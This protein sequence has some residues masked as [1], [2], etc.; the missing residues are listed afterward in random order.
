MDPDAVFKAMLPS[1][2]DTNNDVAG[3]QAIYDQELLAMRGGTDAKGNKITGAL[4]EGVGKYVDQ[5]RSDKSFTDQLPDIRHRIAP[6]AAAVAQALASFGSA[7]SGNQT[8]DQAMR[9]QIQQA[10]Q[11]E[12]AD[13]AQQRKAI[14]EEA[15]NRRMTYLNFQAQQLQTTFQE[16]MRRRQFSAASVTAAKAAEL[17]ALVFNA[18]AEQQAAMKKFDGEVE[19]TKS[20]L[21]AGVFVGPDGKTITTSTSRSA[22]G[23]LFTEKDYNDAV[24][25]NLKAWV[26]A[27]SQKKPDANLLNV[28][29]KR[30][31]ELL[32]TF[33]EN[34]TTE[35][36][37][38]R[39]QAGI[40]NLVAQFGID[41]KAASKVAYSAI[42]TSIRSMV[43]RSVA[44]K[45]ELVPGVAAYAWTLQKKDGDLISAAQFKALTG[46]D[47]PAIGAT[48][49][50]PPPADGTHSHGVDKSIPRGSY[51]SLAGV[52]QEVQRTRQEALK[53]PEISGAVAAGD[54]TAINRYEPYSKAL[55][56]QR[57]LQNPPRPTYPDP[58]IPP[59][60]RAMN[61]MRTRVNNLEA[62][63][64]YYEELHN[65]GYYD[66][67]HD[68]DN[69]MRR[70]AMAL[71]EYQAYV[72]THAERTAPSKVRT[73]GRQTLD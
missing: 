7:L 24:T 32:S 3:Q 47:A 68:V 9:Q 64:R 63:L 69:L 10:E 45:K 49:A 26:D 66:P 59:E 20:L 22:T 48:P 58:S 18:Q 41:E 60:N 29:Q 65:L 37:V 34:E 4:N 42:E 1:D 8:Y 27:A 53:D 31:F 67:G 40:P 5:V 30:H 2:T 39:V 28:L 71:K 46:Q 19:L 6:G 23:G 38:N 14:L 13:K 43:T 16:L 17:Q 36:M 52:E 15:H 73:G 55:R 61:V 57:L 33:H 72:T 25:N 12:Y 70:Y 35:E 56:I 11:D 50:P 51:N 54:E 62:E 44:A 21:A